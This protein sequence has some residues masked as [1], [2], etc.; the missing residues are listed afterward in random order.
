V[1]RQEDQQEHPEAKEQ[2]D[3]LY[4]TPECCAVVK[5]HRTVFLQMDFEEVYKNLPLSPPKWVCRSFDSE[6]QTST[7][8][9]V[10][11][12]PHCGTSVP[13]I[14]LTKTDKKISHT[15]DGHYCSTCS[16][17]LS[18]CSCYDATHAWK[19]KR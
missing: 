10:N 18:I 16:E 19:P 13:A 1:E 2:A 15:E 11:F 7:T 12:C 4:V 3:R 5:I 9:E 8:T 6:S 17:R 14:E